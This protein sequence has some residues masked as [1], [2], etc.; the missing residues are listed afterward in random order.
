MK[1]SIQGKKLCKNMARRADIVAAT[2]KSVL[3]R[4]TLSKISNATVRGLSPFNVVSSICPYISPLP[5]TAD[6]LRLVHIYPGDAMCTDTPLD[7]N[8]GLSASQYPW[9]ANF[10][11]A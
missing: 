5:F 11:A 6:L 10:E 8:S 7:F 1:Y 3:P 9:T 2:I 4:A